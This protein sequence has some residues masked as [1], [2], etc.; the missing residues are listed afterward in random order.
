MKSCMQIANRLSITREAATNLSMY[1]LKNVKQ[2]ILRKFKISK[3]SKLR[4]K[5]TIS[6]LQEKGEKVNSPKLIEEY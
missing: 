3:G 5:R 2:K 1:R 6:D 4:I